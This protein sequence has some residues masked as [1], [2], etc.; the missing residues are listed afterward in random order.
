[1]LIL[2]VDG[3]DHEI[4]KRL[5]HPK[6]PYERKLTIPKE[7]YHK[8]RPHSLK[9]WPSMFSGRIVDTQV[10]NSK[11]EIK[12]EIR[13]TMAS[14]LRSIGRKD[15]IKK[16]KHD[17]RLRQST[18]WR[19]RPDNVD[20]ETVFTDRRSLIWNIP[21]I[22]PECIMHY[23]SVDD[24]LEYAKREQ[25]I[26]EMVVLG[27]ARTSYELCAAYC[28]ELDS[29]GHMNVKP[30][31]LYR[32]LSSFI[33][34]VNKISMHDTIMVVSDHGMN[35]GRHTEYAY[36]GCNKPINAETVMDVR[37]EIERLLLEEKNE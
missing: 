4:A 33:D 7:L 27:M 21:T 12:Y 3:L 17:K 20:I 14:F 26:W 10:W 36:L 35:D 2:A 32:D 18:S 29:L 11:N 1:M 24:M 34:L 5:G 19:I 30:E 37:G 6:M 25:M 9:I 13:K 16:A 28:H 31:P 15:L 23:P 8:G 22:T